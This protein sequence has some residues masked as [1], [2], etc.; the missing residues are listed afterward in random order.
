MS[1]KNLRNTSRTNWT[2]LE[3]MNDEEIDYSDIPPLT[4]DFFQKAT[5]RVPAS[6][7]QQLVQIE[8][9]ILEWFQAQSGE[10]KTLINSVLRRYIKNCDE[11]RA[12]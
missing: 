7:A 5:L 12:V 11:H 1:D 10:Y 6:Q 3:S 9:D 8:P 2:A 4:E